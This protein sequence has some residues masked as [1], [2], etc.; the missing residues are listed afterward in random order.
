M[1]TRREVLHY[2]FF[3][4]LG[5]VLADLVIL[6]LLFN[7]ALGEGMPFGVKLGGPILFLIAA[8][9]YIATNIK[10]HFPRR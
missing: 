7:T 2:F 6:W 4:T 9:L 8:I 1:K 10:L 5:A 3:A